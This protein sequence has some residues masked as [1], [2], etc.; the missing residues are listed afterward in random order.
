[1]DQWGNPAFAQRT[2]STAGARI[3]TPAFTAEEP[4]RTFPRGTAN[5][6]SPHPFSEVYPQS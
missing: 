1:M 4:P 5:D 3:Q 2:K 6:R